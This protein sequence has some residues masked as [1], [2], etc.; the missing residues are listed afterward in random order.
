MINFEIKELPEAPLVWPA[1]KN[2]YIGYCDSIFDKNFCDGVI[3]LCEGQPE[4]FSPGLTLGGVSTHIKNSLDWFLDANYESP[5]NVEQEYDFR[6]H[7]ELQKVVSLY[8]LSYPHLILHCDSDKFARSDTG[9]QVQ[10]YIKNTGNYIEHIDGATWIDS[11]PRT[12]AAILYLNTVTHG[13]GTQFP[14]QN[15]TIDAVAGRVVLFPA[16]W[17]HPHS[18][19]VP[20]SDDKWI[21]STFLF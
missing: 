17:T 20:L 19:L 13:G 2:G 6:I 11:G 14:I 10:K 16:E 5:T 7:A 21:I 1:G 15:V 3:N 18:G 4:R 12:L 9:Y 8:R